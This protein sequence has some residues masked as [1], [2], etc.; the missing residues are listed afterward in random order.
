[1][2]KQS[3]IFGLAILAMVSSAQAQDKNQPQ[4]D[5]HVQSTPSK[6]DHSTLMMQIKTDEKGDEIRRQELVD[7]LRRLYK[8]NFL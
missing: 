3:T 4:A 1:M 6:E 5:K 8:A 2:K 7:E